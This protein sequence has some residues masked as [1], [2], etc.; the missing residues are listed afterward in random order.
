VTNYYTGEA[1]VGG[2]VLDLYDDIF[3]ENLYVIS[4]VTDIPDI[5]KNAEV[6]VPDKVQVFG[7]KEFAL[8]VLTKDN[9]KVR[10]Y[11]ISDPSNTWVSI[12]Y[13]MLNKDKLPYDAQVICAKNLIDAAKKY[14]LEVPLEMKELS[15]ELFPE[16]EMVHK[17]ASL[18]LA[19]SDFGLIRNKDG[20][21]QR[22]YP[23]TS[24]GEIDTYLNKFAEASKALEPTEKVQFAFRLVKK[25][26]NLG[27]NIPDD[28]V[29]MSALYEKISEDKLKIMDRFPVDTPHRVKLAAKYFEASADEMDPATRFNFVSELNDAADKH[30]VNLRRFKKVAKY[31]NK[32]FDL[33]LLKEARDLR[34]RAL[35]ERCDEESLATLKQVF[36]LASVTSP[37]VFSRILDVFDRG[38]N[39]DY[40]WGRSIPSP[41]DILKEASEKQYLN[42]NS[43]LQDRVVDKINKTIHKRR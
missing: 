30:G 20:S 14:Q 27:M 35:E 28:L 3:K 11:L 10:K 13:F 2:L 5:V 17:E 34:K 29:K 40:Y 24:A 7:D 19:D 18:L 36:K 38:C 4:K 31:N 1:K 12:R 32:A 6:T 21:K 9:R 8:I 25:A 16:K 43:I 41:D 39:L 42:Y 15:K 26:R 33:D 22:L 37:P 23:L